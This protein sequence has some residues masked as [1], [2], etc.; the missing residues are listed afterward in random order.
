M[1]TLVLITIL[2]FK[3]F[4]CDFLLQTGNIAM[5]KHNHFNIESYAHS[6]FHALGAILALGVCGYAQYWWVGFISGLVHYGIDWTK[7]NLNEKLQ[8]DPSKTHFWWL[9]GADQL[10]HG[11]TYCMVA[12]VTI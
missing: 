11:L 6:T 12:L 9:L 3:H 4:I 2:L 1:P 5:K 8:L 10:C 7:G